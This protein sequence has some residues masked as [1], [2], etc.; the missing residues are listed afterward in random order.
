MLYDKSGLLQI[1]KLVNDSITHIVYNLLL[2]ISLSLGVPLPPICQPFTF[3]FARL[4]ND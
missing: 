1:E 4:C 2:S 3:I